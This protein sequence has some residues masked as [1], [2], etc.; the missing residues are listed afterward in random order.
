MP[1][2]SVKDASFDSKTTCFT[3]VMGG[4]YSYGRQWLLYDEASVG[5]DGDLG[6][7][8]LV[9]LQRSEHRLA[10]L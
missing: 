8:L 10:C 3:V 9:G 7:A 1:S 2:N 4:G 6:T 5:L